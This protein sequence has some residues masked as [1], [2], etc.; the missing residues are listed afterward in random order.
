MREKKIMYMVG[1]AGFASIGF[2]L[3][4]EAGVVSLP[5]CIVMQ[6]F[7]IN[8]FAS[9]RSRIFFAS[10]FF[11]SLRFASVFFFPLCFSF[12]YFYFRLVSLS[13][14]LFCFKAKINTFRGCAFPFSSL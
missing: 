10:V 9:L 4:S 7:R 3:Q 8:F 11:F 12:P 2:S 1:R 5:F 14:F 6:K 13:Y